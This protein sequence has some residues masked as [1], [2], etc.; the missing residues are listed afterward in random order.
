MKRIIKKISSHAVSFHFDHDDDES[1]DEFSLFRYYNGVIYREDILAKTGHVEPCK[2]PTLHRVD[3]YISCLL[4]SRSHHFET[5][6]HLCCSI[7]I[8]ELYRIIHA[9]LCSENLINPDANFVIMHKDTIIDE[10]DTIT[11]CTLDHE[12]DEEGPLLFSIIVMIEDLATTKTTVISKNALNTVV[13]TSQV[14]DVHI[15]NMDTNELKRTLMWL[16]SDAISNTRV[17]RIFSMI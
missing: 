4:G 11:L 13:T 16:F 6:I 7:T 5:C 2:P 15:E 9:F 1:I 8:T 10:S 3:A 14:L 12:K 17:I